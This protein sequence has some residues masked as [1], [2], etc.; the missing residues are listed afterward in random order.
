M[1]KIKYILF[2]ALCFYFGV[3]FA[4]AASISVKASS[5][6]VVVGN[7]VKVTVTVNGTGTSAGSVG[8]WEYCVTYDSSKLTL[9]SPSSPCV[10]D[11]LVGLTSA[12]T[13]FTF[14]AK[15]SGSSTVSLSTV[16]LYDYDTEKAMSVTKGS[17]KITARTQQEIE[18]SYSDNA[19]LSSLKVDGYSL[20]PA[21]DKSEYS[22]TLEVENDVESI[23]IK[24]TKADS[25][26]SISGT[27]TKT[28]TEGMNTFKVVVTA[29]K[30]NK[31]T[32]TISVN[33]KELNPIEVVVDGENY[34]V[35]RKSDA[36]EAPTYYSSSS[37]T[38]DD[39]EVP[40]FTSEITGYTLVG[41]K[42][43]DGEIALFRYID[44]MYAPY[45][46]IGTDGFVFVPEETTQLI[47][48][49]SK[50][51]VIPINEQ[52]VTVYFL[53]DDSDFVLLYGMNVSTG[54]R[55]WYKYDRKEGTFQRYESLAV[56]TKED[57]DLYFLLTI[58]FASLS[59][60]SILLLI[61][62]MVLNSKIRKKNTKLIAMIENNQL[63]NEKV[64]L[65]T[66]EVKEQ[67]DTL[68]NE[69]VE[70]EEVP[71]EEESSIEETIIQ[72]IAKSNSENFEPELQDTKID[73]QQ[74]FESDNEVH[75]TEIL[76]EIPVY[77]ETPSVSEKLSKRE[78]RRLEK[79]KQK[80][81]Q[82]EIRKM[83]EDFLKTQEQTVLEEEEKVEKVKKTRGRK[84]K[85]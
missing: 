60:L 18:A 45:I 35:V 24:A 65:T 41:L 10:N 80:K 9:T 22:Y 73:L 26:A 25:G 8:A 44:G 11:G 38:I 13:V 67:E 31:K 32:Y 20:S 57:N 78:I 6:S 52:D 16:A 64:D 7:T 27:G 63:K 12:S 76:E 56:S 61:L 58:V 62:L 47:E 81:E 39:N 14:K 48:G 4:S 83:Q 82:E 17:V 72:N 69:V 85:K 3:G 19:Y 74:D 29:E 50:T 54:E 70:K 59:G 40:A 51:K 46:Q 30:G 49:Y 75:D 43:E 84:R 66:E 37:V 28:L 53:E 1:K 42:N 71:L 33:R 5:S 55:D 36:L 15:A 23:T 2:V 68:E 79:E 77:E 34:T 21:F